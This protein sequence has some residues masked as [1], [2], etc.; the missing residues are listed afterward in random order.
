MQDWRMTS[1]HPSAYALVPV[2]SGLLAALAAVHVWRQRTA[3]GGAAALALLGM[4]FWSFGYGVALGVHD[5]PARIFWAKV[6]YIGIGLLAVS[7]PNLPCA[8]LG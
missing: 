5:L 8:T 4:A 7:G 3:P 1:W 6:Q 2:A